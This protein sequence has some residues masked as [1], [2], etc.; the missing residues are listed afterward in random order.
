M[1]SL[2]FL[3]FLVLLVCCRSIV[4]DS[5]VTDPRGGGEYHTD[6]HVT[7]PF[8]YVFEQFCLF[9]KYFI[10][11]KISLFTLLRAEIYG[12]ANMAPL[13]LFVCK[14]PPFLPELLKELCLVRILCL[15]YFKPFNEH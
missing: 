13:V 9:S 4:P 5:H 10:P 14:V 8:F 11:E 12:G 1:H 7:D 2:L 6:S 15:I 3:Y